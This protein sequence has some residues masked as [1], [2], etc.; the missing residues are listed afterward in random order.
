MH[1]WC[2]RV[3]KRSSMGQWCI[4]VS[5]IKKIKKNLLTSS[6]KHKC[7]VLRNVF[8]LVSCGKIFQEKKAVNMTCGITIKPN[9]YYY[10]LNIVK[11]ISQGKYFF[12]SSIILFFH[13]FF[14]ELH[15]H[16]QQPEITLPCHAV[17]IFSCLCFFFFSECWLHQLWF[18]RQ[19]IC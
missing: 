13:L 18:G 14:W 11:Y 15:Q 17:D 19:R 16:W 4:R 1:Y 12:I 10:F 7:Y 3:K 5:W 6:L 2:I 9:Y 8:M